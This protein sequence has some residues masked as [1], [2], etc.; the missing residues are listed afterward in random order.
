VSFSHR[1]D[2]IEVRWTCTYTL[3]IKSISSPTWITSTW[4]WPLRIGA[5]CLLMTG[6]N[7]EV[8]FVDIWSKNNRISLTRTLE[9]LSDLC[10]QQTTTCKLQASTCVLKYVLHVSD[11][12]VDYSGL[13]FYLI[14]SPASDIKLLI[15]IS[16]L[17]F[18]FL[19]LAVCRKHQSWNG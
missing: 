11:S 19:R 8:A 2:W 12:K 1:K 14:I 15:S 18:P 5:I 13:R 4:I 7:V 17:K 10:P 16:E 6:I 3:T 9:M